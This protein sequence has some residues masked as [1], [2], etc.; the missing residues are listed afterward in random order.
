M[1]ILYIEKTF[2]VSY[3]PAQIYNLLHK[4]GFT[5]QRGRA[6][7]SECEEREEKVQ[8]IKKLQESP[9]ESVVVFENEASLSNMATVFCK[10]AVRKQ[11]PRISIL[12]RGKERKTI[13]GCVSPIF[14][15]SYADY[16]YLHSV[17][18]IVPASPMRRKE[19]PNACSSHL[20][21]D[22]QPDPFEPPG[23]E[24]RAPFARFR[25]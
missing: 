20:H 18:D 8:A 5:F 12:Q 14:F 2:G 6:V 25:Q 10:W 13:S 19:A 21:H 17:S 16:G 3:K 22:A 1:L 7:Y 15:S 24:V 9:P 23:A 4:L 11:Q